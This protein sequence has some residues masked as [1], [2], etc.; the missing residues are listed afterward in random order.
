MRRFGF[1]VWLGA[2]AARSGGDVGRPGAEPAAIFA[3][4]LLFS[5]AAVDETDR[6]EADR[7]LDAGRKPAEMLA[8]FGVMP[9]MAV[10]E[11]GSGGGYTAELLARTVGPVGRVYGQNSPL[12]LERFA[13]AP[14]ADRLGKPVM[15]TVTRLDTEFAAPFPAELDGSLDVVLDVLFYHD[16]VWMEVDR[17]AMN[18]AIFRA[19]KPGGVYGIVDHAARPEDGATVTQTLHRIDE[20]VVIDEITAADDARDWNPSPRAAGERRG[21]SDR[22]VLRFRKPL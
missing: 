8:F 16:T 4:P 6:D 2:C 1:V 14:W 13:E 22:F 19:L 15:A 17:A 7:A 11:I 10:G 20:R 9:G 3:D 21:E 12:I 5:Q 18:A